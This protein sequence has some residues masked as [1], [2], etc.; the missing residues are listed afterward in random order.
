[1][2]ERPWQKTTTIIQGREGR[3][4]AEERSRNG[5]RTSDPEYIL[6]IKL[7]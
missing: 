3:V 6:E 7:S 5:Q 4:D 1:M 2:A